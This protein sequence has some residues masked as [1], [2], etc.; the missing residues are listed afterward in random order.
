MMT[1][2]LGRTWVRETPELFA[3]SDGMQMMASVQ[4]TDEYVMGEINR[5]PAYAAQAAEKARQ[6]GLKASRAAK[7]AAI[8]VTT[9]TG[10][11]FDGD[12]TSQ[13]RMARAI[14]TLQA[15]GIGETEW[16]LVDNTVQ[17]VQLG[18]LVE[19]LMLSG[20]AQTALW[21]V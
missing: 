2:D 4:M 5:L 11:T 8:Q 19:A 18:E 15:V 9:S 1:D 17:T 6:A 21:M 10:K 14:V 16:K 7:V 12:E 13:G 20:Q 3:C